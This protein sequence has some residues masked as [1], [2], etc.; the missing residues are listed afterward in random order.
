[1]AELTSID[2]FRD[3]KHYTEIRQKIDRLV[4]DGKLTSKGLDPTERSWFVEMY[5]T[6]GGET[7]LLAHPDQ[8]FRGYLR[9]REP[10]KLS[11]H[12]DPR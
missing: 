3:E 8:A 2:N 9:L 11:N 6:S 10:R 7:W 4:R 5:E 12:T 1:M